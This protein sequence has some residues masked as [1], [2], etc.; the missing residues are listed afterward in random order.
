MSDIIAIATKTPSVN[1][2]YGTFVI[3]SKIK[4]KRPTII[5]GMKTEFKNVKKEIE[6]QLFSINTSKFDKY[7][8]KKSFVTLGVHGN[9]HNKDG[10]VKKKDIA[11][12]EK[13][14]TDTVFEYLGLKDQF[15]FKY[16]LIKVQSETEGFVLDIDFIEGETE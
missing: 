14:I 2:V 6:R 13:F 11:N 4:G 5:R 9:W 12:Y 3:P 7:K 15:I 16:Y 1:Q 8:E 10:S